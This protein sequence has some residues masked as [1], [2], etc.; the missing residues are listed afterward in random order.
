MLSLRSIECSWALPQC[1][2]WCV[3]YTS[4]LTWALRVIWY[5]SL[6]RTQPHTHTL[7]HVRPRMHNYTQWNCGRAK[8]HSMDNPLGAH[9]IDLYFLSWSH[10]DYN[11]WKPG[12]LIP[13]HYI[14]ESFHCPSISNTFLN[15][16]HWIDCLIWYYYS[17]MTLYFLYNVQN[18]LAIFV[19][20]FYFQRVRGWEHTHFIMICFPD[21][22]VP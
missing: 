21:T 1:H 6:A 20:I 10:L 7:T 8:L 5:W 19:I 13:S 16:P 22:I 3:F 18:N 12:E 4:L 11:G 17:K 9:S 14:E 2:V 15:T